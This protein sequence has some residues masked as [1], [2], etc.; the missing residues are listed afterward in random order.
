M[1]NAAKQILGSR[2][3]IGVIITKYYHAKAPIDGFTIFEAGHP[4]P[5]NKT[6]AATEFALNLTKNLTADDTV[7]FLLSGGGS[8]LFE[9]P[10]VPEQ[11]LFDITERLLASGA[12]IVEINTIRKRL[13]KVKGGRFALHCAPAKVF[14]IVLSDIIGNRLDMI[15]SGPTAADS[16]A[17]EDAMRI[18]KKNGIELTENTRTALQT[19]TSV[20]CGYAWKLKKQSPY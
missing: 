18:V 19:E 16:T 2:I 17:Y 20:I 7:L 8:S 11:E 10:L 9:L 14:S 3:D 12:D 1:A 15:A 5:D 6:F 13:S 4:V